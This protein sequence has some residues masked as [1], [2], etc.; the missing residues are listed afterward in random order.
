L[1]RQSAFVKAVKQQGYS[2]HNIGSW[3]HASNKAPL[4]DADYMYDHR[5]SAFGHTKRL[6][7]IEATQFG[8]SPYYQFFTIP[9]HRWPLKTE[10]RD[11]VANVREQLKVLDSLTTGPSPGGRFI[12]THILIPHDPFVFNADGSTSAHPTPDNEGLAVKT[13]Y[14]NQVQFINDQMRSVIDQIDKQSD[15]KAVIVLNADEG[16]YPQVM[17]ASFKNPGG[18]GATGEDIAV[19]DMSTWSPDWLQM[20][21]GILQAAR[22]PKASASD[23]AKLSSVNAFRLVLNSY[24]HYQLPYLPNCHYGYKDTIKVFDYTDLTTKI[25]DSA[26]GCPVH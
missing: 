16:P 13:K 23:M 2:F 1:I 3:Y 12:F 19:S 26:D 4:A 18:A 22:V 9:S 11:Q 17:T 14:T 8:Q 15:G 7:G 25:G 21:Y 20:K 5:I 6:L 24:F 10:D